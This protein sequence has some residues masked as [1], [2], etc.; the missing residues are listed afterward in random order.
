MGELVGGKSNAKK[1]NRRQNQ[2]VYLRW[3]PMG[4]IFLLG[5]GNLELRRCLLLWQAPNL[6]IVGDRN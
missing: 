4:Q 5:N 3:T 6:V 1:N 2:S